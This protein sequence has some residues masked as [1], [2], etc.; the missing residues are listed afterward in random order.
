MNN[1]DQINQMSDSIN[2]FAA[3]LAKAQGEIQPACKDK[4][5]P[6]FKSKYADLG[7]IWDACRSSL[8][9][10]GL[11]VTQTISTRKEGMFLITTLLHASGQWMK[12]EMPVIVS[13][14]DPQT[15]GSAL[16][17]YR[18]YCLAAMVGVAPEDDD[19]EKAQSMYRA[20][21]SPE[22]HPR[23]KAMPPEPTKISHQQA[24]EMEMILGDC[25]E[26]YRQW[27]FDVIKKQYDA[28]TL[29]Q[30]PADIY[31]RMKQ[32]AIK[33]ME[34]NHAKQRMQIAPETEMVL[35]DMQ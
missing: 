12:S 25:D 27:V 23:R 1:V 13:K 24:S 4:S 5:N 14:Q 9:K 32:A 11:C 34:E 18:R 10:N 35:Q 3:A 17:Y 8:S 26:K 2:E 28:D 20:H 22:E 16:T 21:K 6:Y 19:G 30:V 31:D 15:L 29:I 7:S 33:N